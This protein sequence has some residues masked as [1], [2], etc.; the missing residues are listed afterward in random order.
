MASALIC[1]RCGKV[2]RETMVTRSKFTLFSSEKNDNP[3]IE[4]VYN[5][6]RI[7]E[8]LDLCDTC[9]FSLER[10]IEAEGGDKQ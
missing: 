3:L 1:D 6:S 8:P 2:F 4:R 7:G 10:W 5:G 9:S